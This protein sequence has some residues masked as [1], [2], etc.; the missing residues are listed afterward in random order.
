[1]K[2]KHNEHAPANAYKDQPAYVGAATAAGHGMG[3]GNLTTRFANN[4]YEGSGHNDRPTGS[5]PPHE[6]AHQ[7]KGAG[8]PPTRY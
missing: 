5:E 6:K 4:N 2:C 1:M 8:K 3:G 7:R